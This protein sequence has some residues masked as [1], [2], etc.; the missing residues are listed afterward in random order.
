VIIGV[1]I[2][3]IEVARIR[4]AWERSPDRFLARHFTP[5]EIAYALTRRDPAPHLAARFAAKEA[6]QKAWPA[7]H[8]WREVWV[9]KDGPTPFIGLAPRL[10]RRL[11]EEGWRVHL[12][13]SHTHEHA[14]AIVVVEG[15]QPPA[16]ARS[17]GES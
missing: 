12:S 5:G 10:E 7:S 9:V 8:G 2:D 16:W 6:F 15:A 1:G 17:P 14:Q 11:Q 3:L 13:L 4:R